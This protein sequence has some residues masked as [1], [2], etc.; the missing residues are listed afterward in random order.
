M[1]NLLNM[2]RFICPLVVLGL[3]FSFSFARA[4]NAIQVPYSFSF[5]ESESAELSQWVLNPG[6]NTS[7]LLDQWVV[8]EATHSDGHRSAYISCNHGE[9]ANFAVTTNIQYLYRDFTLPALKKNSSI[10]LVLM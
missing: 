9:D 6:D 4:Q 7:A 8:G 2:N 10:L 1:Q 5:E 3:L